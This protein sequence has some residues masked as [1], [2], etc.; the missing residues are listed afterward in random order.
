MPIDNLYYE[1]LD[2]V[3]EDITIA[4]PFIVGCV[5]VLLLR[6]GKK[7]SRSTVEE[8]IGNMHYHPYE[9]QL[10]LI[11][12]MEEGSLSSLIASSIDMS[13]VVKEIKIIHDN[14]ELADID[15]V[16]ENMHTAQIKVMVRMLTNMDKKMK[17][18]RKY[19]DGGLF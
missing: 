1:C 13:R 11:S 8:N 18:L 2:R 3:N 7:I 6:Y 10:K 12:T 15:E 5:Y 14:I 4:E 17:G 19:R 9:R 16:T